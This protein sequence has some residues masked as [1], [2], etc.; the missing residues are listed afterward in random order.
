VSQLILTD[1]VCKDALRQLL[2]S[3][4]EY[5]SSE[6]FMGLISAM[7]LPHDSS[8]V[9]SQITEP[10]FPGYAQKLL[11]YQFGPVATVVPGQAQTLQPTQSFTTSGAGP[12][13][14]LGW[15]FWIRNA[16]Q[17]TIFELFDTPWQLTPGNPLV[18][19]AQLN[20]WSRN[21]LP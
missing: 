4:L 17:L 1:Y 2:I 6:F 11:S 20:M 13:P 10:T 21:V 9:F 12:Y 8:A 16:V 19:Q 15:F 7:T 3:S 5:Q 18:I 14:I